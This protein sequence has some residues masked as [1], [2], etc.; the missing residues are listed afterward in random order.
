[1][2]EWKKQQ[3]QKIEEMRIAAQKNTFVIEEEK[4]SGYDFT[5]HTNLGYFDCNV[6]GGDYWLYSRKGR[7]IE[8]NS[9]PQKIID[10]I[11]QILNS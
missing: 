5:I 7:V 11:N 9:D 1:M 2:H 10:C 8:I 4:E 3:E 6:F